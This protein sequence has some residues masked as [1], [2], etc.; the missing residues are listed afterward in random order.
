MN[1]CIDRSKGRLLNPSLRLAFD[2]TAARSRRFVLKM[3][4]P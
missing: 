4:S 1:L 3:H 2:T